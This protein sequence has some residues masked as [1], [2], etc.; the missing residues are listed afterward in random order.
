MVKYQ[1]TVGPSMITK[2]LPHIEFI[3]KKA[4]RLARVEKDSL[5]KIMERERTNSDNGNILG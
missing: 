5:I 3:I 4:H 1:N 2:S